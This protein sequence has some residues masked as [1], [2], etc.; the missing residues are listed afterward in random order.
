MRSVMIFSVVALAAA[1]VV[2]RYVTQT[3][4]S[5]PTPNLMAAH[6]VPTPPAAAPEISDSRAV[7]IAPNPQGHFEVE[8][9]IDGRRLTFM[10]DTGASMI[11][12]NASSKAD[13]GIRSAGRG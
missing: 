6:P 7:T 2:P 5:R 10:V 1:L 9:R 8:G 4:A 11:A 12:R 13:L 3:S